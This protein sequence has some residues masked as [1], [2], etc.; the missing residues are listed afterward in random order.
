MQKDGRVMRV[1]AVGCCP[2]RLRCPRAANFRGCIW[3]A[4]ATGARLPAGA[5][6]L[7]DT[8]EAPSQQ[9]SRTPLHKALRGPPDGESGTSAGCKK[10]AVH[11]CTPHGCG[12]AT[13]WSLSSQSPHHVCT[14]EY[15]WFVRRMPQLSCCVAN[16]RRRHGGE[17]AVV[18]CLGRQNA[19]WVCLLA[20]R[21]GCAEAF[22]DECMID[23]PKY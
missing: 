6:A 22:E 18:Q 11:I 23:R 5:R 1:W 16:S 21:R 2:S 10:A 7:R 3:H 12:R 17:L 13:T 15:V 19:A 4:R 9:P 20:Q 14:C 8:R